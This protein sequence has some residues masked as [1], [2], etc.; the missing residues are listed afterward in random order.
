V[1]TGFVD[2]HLLLILEA[3]DPQGQPLSP[4]KG[5]PLLPHLA[6]KTYAGRA[7]RLYAKQL[8]DFDGRLPV[9]FWRARPETLDTRL[10]PGKDD[11]STYRFGGRADRVRVRLVY[12]RFWEETVQTKGWPDDTLVVKQLEIPMDRERTYQ[13]AAR[14]ASGD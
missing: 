1:P 11:V 7:G 6:G 4:V 3:L 2:R 13:Q 12:R 14:R 5:T 8:R 10:S 9:P